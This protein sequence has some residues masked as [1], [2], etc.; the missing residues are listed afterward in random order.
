MSECSQLRTW[1]LRRPD[2]ALREMKRVVKPGGRVVICD[3]CDDY[4][5]C[6]LC[7]RIL[8]LVNRA[9]HK[10]YGRSEC[11]SM[12]RLAGFEVVDIERFKITWL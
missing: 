4:L 9:H 5:A 8:R 2:A 3:W 10:T 1:T 12:L 6:R 7:D 11:I